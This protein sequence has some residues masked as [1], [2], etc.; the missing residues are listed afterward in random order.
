LGG[1]IQK[2]GGDTES[3]SLSPNNRSVVINDVD[4]FGLNVESLIIKEVNPRKNSTPIGSNNANFSDG[5]RRKTGGLKGIEGAKFHIPNFRDILELKSK[6]LMKRNKPKKVRKG[7][8]RNS[9]N[10]SPGKSRLMREILRDS[11]RE[12]LTHQN[13]ESKR[14]LKQ[15]VQASIA[16]DESKDTT[17]HKE[18]SKNVSNSPASDSIRQ[19]D[20]RTPEQAYPSTPNKITSEFSY[21]KDRTPENRPLDPE[22]VLGVKVR[23]DP[24]SPPP[25]FDIITNT[26]GRED[27]KIYNGK[28]PE[29][30]DDKQK[31]KTGNEGEKLKEMLTDGPK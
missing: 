21:S 2:L 25:K 27:F 18:S 24:I 30:A 26:G 19:Q 13:S 6:S 15:I 17:E 10:S 11:S 22:D 29:V 16:G 4:D 31:L 9:P 20:F 12:K 5:N 28:E 14:S 7:H 8:S 3:K 1:E 23:E